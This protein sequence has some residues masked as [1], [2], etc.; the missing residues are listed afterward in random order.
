MPVLPELLRELDAAVKTSFQASRDEYFLK[1]TL[2]TVAVVIGV[3]IE[4]LEYF[5]SWRSV[6]SLLPTKL[7]L[8]PH[9]LETVARRV[10]KIGWLLIVLGVAGEGLYEA[11][12]SA[13][14]GWLQEFNNTLFIAQE[15]EIT[16]LGNITDRARNDA[17]Q[18]AEESKRATASAAAAKDLAT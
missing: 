16:E 8:P 5:L 6:R 4:E 14:D 2:S 18:A 7:L 15:A 3:A 12:V 9:R 1:L 17:R 10:S 11:R 13:A